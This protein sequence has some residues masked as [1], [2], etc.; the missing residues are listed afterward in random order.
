M[1]MRSWWWVG[2]RAVG[3]GDRCVL[4]GE[5]FHVVGQVVQTGL[6]L[7]TR[8]LQSSARRRS[9]AR[10]SSATSATT[11]IASRSV[12]GASNTTPRRSSS[13]IRTR[14]R[15]RRST[16]S[17]WS[18]ATRARRTGQK[19]LGFLAAGIHIAELQES[20]KLAKIFDDAFG[21]EGEARPSRKLRDAARMPINP[22]HDRLGKSELPD[23]AAMGRQG[24][25]QARRAALRAAAPHRLYAARERRAEG[26]HRRDEGAGLGGA[27]QGAG[28]CDL[29]HAPRC[30]NKPESC[31][32]Q[33]V[34]EGDAAKDL[35]P[36]SAN[37]DYAKT[38]AP[39][40]TSIRI[41]HEMPHATSFWSRNSADGRFV[42]SGGSEAGAFVVDFAKQL[43]SNGAE[44]REIGVSASYDPS[45]MPSNSGLLIQGGGTHFCT[46]D[47]FTNAATTSV[48]FQEP[49]C[50]SLSDV[51][52]YQSVGRRL[53][54]NQ[55][56]DYSSSTTASRATTA[57]EKTPRPRS[58]KPKISV[59]VMIGTGTEAGY[60]SARSKTSTRRGKATP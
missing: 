26:A 27:Q 35:F 16:I 1:R 5:R 2:A 58:V 15:S 32:T 56:S 13:T 21:A 33:K 19:R 57:T 31:F 53:A 36:L 34:G 51:A 48:S 3:G 24:D 22:N 40:G 28:R 42:S 55:M 12:C 54:D 14:P 52:L 10:S 6:E 11:S 30:E 49:Q 18:R 59:K 38:W 60:Q 25:A 29:S 20:K 44:R 7:A 43:T 37:V 41:V 8:A 39:E 4:V 45:F 50:S 17:A 23:R 46:Q 47:L 9:M